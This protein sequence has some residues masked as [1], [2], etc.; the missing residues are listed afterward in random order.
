MRKG[1]ASLKHANAL[2]PY[3]PFSL[4]FAEQ[5]NGGF[6]LSAPNSHPNGRRSR[7]G[8]LIKSS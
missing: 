3:V 5:A 1:K 4:A 6:F 7:A 2:S 8:Y